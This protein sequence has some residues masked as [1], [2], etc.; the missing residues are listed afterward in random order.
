MGGTGRWRQLRIL[1]LLLVLLFVALTTAQNRWRTTD[2]DEPL[3]VAVHPI[4]GDGSTAATQM[5]SALNGDHYAAVERF[6]ER[7]AQRYG[8]ALARPVQLHLAEQVHQR[9]PPPPSRTWWKVAWWSL[10]LRYWAWQATRHSSVPSDI[11]L[12]V[13]YHDPA[14]RPALEHSY[15]LAKALVGVAHVFAAH[16]TRGR[17]QIV[18][19]HELFHTLGATDKYDPATTLP[20]FPAGYAN[21]DRRPLLPQNRAELMAGRVP[22][23]PTEAAM[24]DHLDMVLVGPQTALE[25]GW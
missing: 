17:N 5:I 20:H 14:A 23:T 18:I 12:F 25:I 2:W 22:L 11:E 6:V 9:P 10:K 13:V 19:A 3:W 1:V 7:E 21:P 15:G 4:N 16:S 24:P 8:I